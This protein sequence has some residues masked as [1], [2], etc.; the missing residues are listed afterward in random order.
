MEHTV[1]SVL[2]AR[3]LQGCKDPRVICSP[4]MRK[5][6][7]TCVQESGF[8]IMPHR[9]LGIDIPWW[10]QVLFC[11]FLQ[12]RSPWESLQRFRL[13]KPWVRNGYTLA[14][15]LAESS[16]VIHTWDDHNNNIAHVTLEYCNYTRDNGDKAARLWDSLIA[17]F[18]PSEIVP[19]H[20]STRW[21]ATVKR[22]A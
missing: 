17:L 4:A 2:D 9:I 11:S 6:I 12:W 14:I 1:E 20:L 7:V 15:I 13:R 8:H 22:A 21:V 19:R 5:R 10:L 16:L 18:Q 3:D